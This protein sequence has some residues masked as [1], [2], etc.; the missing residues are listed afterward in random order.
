MGPFFIAIAALVWA[1]DA[2]FR[3]PAAQRIGS[4]WV[5]FFEHAIAVLALLPWAFFNADALKRL[6]WL[7][8]IGVGVVGIGA[9][10]GATLL[11]TS[12]FHYIN[13]SVS[14][15]TLKIQPVF[16]TLLAVVFLRERP[17]LKFFLWSLLA[18]A[19]VT[20]LN[21]PDFDFGFVK[22]D[23]DLRSKGFVLALGASLIWGLSTVVSKALLA[24]QPLLVVTFWRFFFGLI[25]AAIILMLSKSSIQFSQLREIELLRLLLY[26]GL[27]TGLGAMLLYYFG[28]A[29]TQ[30]SLAAFIELLFPLG[31]IVLNAVYLDAPMLATQVFAGLV[32][33][34]AVTMISVSRK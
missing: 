13:P 30:A 15:L 16:A 3:F 33:L 29:Q 25:G 5:V 11:F 24:R 19:S 1:T 20:V 21:F 26:T 8:W 4:A 27:F 6:K 17:G 32:L 34:F 18:L 23:L 12:S 31:A 7:E 2:L 10:A 28:L 14:I 9:S 22:H